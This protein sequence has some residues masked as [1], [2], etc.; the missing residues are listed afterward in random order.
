MLFLIRVPRKFF[1]SS[2]FTSPRDAERLCSFKIFLCRLLASKPLHTNWTVRIRILS[3][4]R[5]YFNIRL[6]YTVP[7]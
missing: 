2:A 3:R 7:R 1:D 4:S 5:A 6:P